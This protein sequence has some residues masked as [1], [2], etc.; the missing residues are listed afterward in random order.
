[1]KKLLILGGSHRD[2]PLI[3]AAQELGYFVST[4]GDRDYYLGH[5]YSDMSYRVNFNDLDKVKKIINDNEIDYIIP[6]SGEESYLNTVEIAQDLNIGNFDDL[7][8]AKLVHNKW[9]FKEFCLNNSIS[10]PKGFYYT[11]DSNLDNLEFPIVVKPTNL[12]GGRGVDVVHNLKE[13]EK[14]LLKAK[15]FSNEIF[16]E[17]FIDGE[18]IAYSLFIKNQKIIYGF[19]GKDDIYKNKYLITSAYPTQLEEIVLERLE[20][21]IE[22]LAKLLALVDGMFHLQVIIKN[23]TPYIIDV[24]RRIPGDFYPNLIEYCDKIDYSKA[25]VNAYIGE[26]LKD[27]LRVREEKEF[28]IRHCV[29]SDKNGL[30]QKIKIDDK[31]RKKIIFRFD[32]IDEHTRIESFLTTQIAIILIK[33]PYEDKEILNNINK[34]VYPLVK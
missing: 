11:D 5:N 19:T 17:E 16:L 12:S 24:T 29:M 28:V 22:K 2:I 26:A 33:L 6:G 20:Y 1:M 7:E 14:S 31:L 34:L 13:L 21:D 23:K 9:K 30:Y 4:L 8:T 18:L 3:K 25:V 10:T 27:E 32:I 15:E